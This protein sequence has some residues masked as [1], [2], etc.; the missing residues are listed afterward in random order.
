M[1]HSAS[2]RMSQSASALQACSHLAVESGILDKFTMTFLLKSN[3]TKYTK[4]NI[5]GL[6]SMPHF[7]H[8]GGWARSECSEVRSIIKHSGLFVLELTLGNWADLCV[9]MQLCANAKAGVI[10]IETFSLCLNGGRGMVLPERRVWGCRP[11]TVQ[12]KLA[13]AASTDI[14]DVPES[15][16]CYFL[17]VVAPSACFSFPNSC[18]LFV[19]KPAAAKW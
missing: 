9:I 15:P 10:I 7:G 17:L 16:P 5:S 11:G 19:L 8:S 3:L 2:Q 4:T 12:S 14:V 13:F 1:S 6:G 18:N